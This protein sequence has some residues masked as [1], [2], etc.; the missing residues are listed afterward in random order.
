MDSISRKSTSVNE[1]KGSIEDNT[2]R[3]TNDEMM[4]HNSET[5]VRVIR[6]MK[7]SAE[8]ISLSCRSG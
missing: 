8:E 4:A 5:V 7:I 2:D 6:E 1:I 3:K